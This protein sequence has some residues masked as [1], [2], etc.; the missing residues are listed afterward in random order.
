[1]ALFKKATKSQSKLR[2][3]L[4]G[5]TGSGKTYTALRIAKGLGQRIAVIDTE[6]G[7]ARKYSGDVA[8]FDVLELE[9]FA[10]ATYVEA[11]KAAEAEGFDVLIID[12]LSHAWMGKEGALEQ[13]DKIGK[14]KGSGDGGGNFGAWR[15][16]TP[17]H[18]G[19]VDAILGARM[20]VICTL[21]VKMEYVMEEDSRGKKSVRK[22]GLQPQQRD[23]VEYEFD[24]IADI[25]QEHNLIVSKSRCSALDKA[26]IPNAGPEVAEKLLAWLGDG[27]P[28]VP[29]A[30]KLLADIRSA[31]TLED[32]TKAGE[33]AKAQWG[34]LS[35]EERTLITDEMRVSLARIQQAIADAEEL[36]RAEREM[37]AAAG[38]GA[39]DAAQERAASN[40]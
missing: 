31:K 32:R 26:V 12:S 16:V 19:L 7:T 29:L 27:A 15:E 9:T 2:L 28:V 17:M 24:V 10:P 21:R 8:E 38:Q 1:M 34:K 5:P 39:V 30:D 13:V 33:A 14:R 35:A 22:I 37:A 25:D 36:E 20:H 23:G 6:R 11:I 18:N 4:L 40:G 3:A